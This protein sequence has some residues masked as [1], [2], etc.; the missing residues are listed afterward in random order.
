[1]LHRANRGILASAGGGATRGLFFTNSAIDY[2]EVATTGSGTSFGSITS[3]LYTHV[4]SGASSTRAVVSSSLSV[5]YV[6]IATTGNTTLFDT[7]TQTLR[8]SG[9]CSN[10]TKACFGGGWNNTGPGSN[11]YGYWENGV[12]SVTIATTGTYAYFGDCSLDRGPQGVASTTRAIFAGGY[13]RAGSGTYTY[14]SAIRYLTFASGG[15]YTA[16]GTLLGTNYYMGGASSST[17]GLF[18]GGASATSTIQY[19]TMATTGNSTLFG[20]ISATSD[21]SGCSS[22]TIALFSDGAPVY[23]V[24]I[25]TTGNATSFG[26]LTIASPSSGTSNGHGGL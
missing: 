9:G 25:A 22:P 11:L 20:S 6:T 5:D 23:A 10:E 21:G 17:R 2:V 3:S 4:C 16:F 26:S 15:A 14:Y 1:M 19:I 24:T 13:F 18:A 7:Y 12:Y 8:D